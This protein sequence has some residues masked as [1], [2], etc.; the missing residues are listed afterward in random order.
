MFGGDQ[1]LAGDSYFSRYCYIMYL[2]L[3]AVYGSNK[4]QFSWDGNLLPHGYNVSDN[5]CSSKRLARTNTVHTNKV[6][7]DTAKRIEAGG[8]SLCFEQ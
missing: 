3:N 8:L 1:I 7:S 2:Y 5:S 6:R 4:N